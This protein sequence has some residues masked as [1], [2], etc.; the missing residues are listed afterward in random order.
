MSTDV[1]GATFALARVAMGG[2]DAL[3]STGGDV[4]VGFSGFSAWY[5]LSSHRK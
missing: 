5:F 1:G 4:A 2:G 3:L